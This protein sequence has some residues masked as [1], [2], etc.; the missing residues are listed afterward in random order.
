MNKRKLP[1]AIVWTADDMRQAGAENNRHREPQN[2]AVLNEPAAGQPMV[3]HNVIE[4]MPKTE[5]GASPETAPRS[6]PAAASAADEALLAQRRLRA[7]AIVARHANFSAIGGMI[8]IPIANVAGVT[9]I[10]V[11]MV[12][13][14]SALYEVP[15]ERT[16]AR[17][18][19][20]GL[21]GGV[22]P[23]GLAIVT[24]STLMYFIP[25]ANLVGLAVSSVSASASA[26]AIGQIF[27]EHFE[28]GSSLIDFPSA[29]LR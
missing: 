12:R 26:R 28:N 24:T 19:V 29:V 15:F 17:A 8:P 22:M 13:S 14:L 2:P 11:R 1:K 21:M 18:I 7:R 20:I 27:I 23:S 25:G 6:A 3:S 16:R 4:M 5:P 9:A 10:L